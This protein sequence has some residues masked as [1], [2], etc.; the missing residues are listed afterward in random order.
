MSDWIE[1]ETTRRLLRQWKGSDRTPFATL[2]A[3]PRVMAYFPAPLAAAESDDLALRC[4]TRIRERGWGLWAVE[5]KH[6]G[7]FIGFVGLNIPPPSGPSCPASKSHGV[8]RFSHWG[9][10]LATEAAHE[11]LRVA[12]ESLGLNE[13]LSWTAVGNWRSRGVMKRLGMQ[14]NICFDHPDLPH[15]S[16]LRRHVLYRLPRTLAA[17]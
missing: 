17:A 16:P 3:D 13:V 2:N 1:P 10:G 14:A 12:F 8:W 5:S 4:A 6:D 7:A 15:D 9:R 11:V